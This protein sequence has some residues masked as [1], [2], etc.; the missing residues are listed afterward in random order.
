VTR[1]VRID[2]PV[3]QENDRIARELRQRFDEA[4]TLCLNLIS[5]P[6]AGKTTLLEKTLEASDGRRAAVLTGDL[7]TDNDARRLARFGHPVRQLVTGGVCHL[8][9]PRI[10]TAL[11]RSCCSA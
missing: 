5:S 2:A 4:R 1:T 9:A 11:D 3:M 10:A 8:D 6:G 7:A